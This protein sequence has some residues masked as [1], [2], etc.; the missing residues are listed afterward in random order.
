MP[1]FVWL[2][3][4]WWNLDRRDVVGSN[5]GQYGIRK[6]NVTMWHESIGLDLC[7][8]MSL[9]IG[10]LKLQTWYLACRCW[11]WKAYINHENMLTNKSNEPWPNWRRKKHTISGCPFKP[12]IAN[13]WLES[14]VLNLHL[15]FCCFYM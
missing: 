5:T 3:F 12:I 4:Q 1:R 8:R 9:K 11:P 2:V 10:H 13:A 6:E 14:Q 7:N 15:L